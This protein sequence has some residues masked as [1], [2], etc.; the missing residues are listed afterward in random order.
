MPDPADLPGDKR[1]TAV[2]ELLALKIENIALNIR[3]MQ[4]E[5]EKLVAQAR[6]AAQA[7]DDD[8]YNMN[9]RCFQ[10]RTD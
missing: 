6:A 10:P 8:I 2:P 9:T 4:H 1:Q 5:Q 7:H 3:L